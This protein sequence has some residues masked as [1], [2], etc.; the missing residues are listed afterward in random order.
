MI[1]SAKIKAIRDARKDDRGAANN[2]RKYL[3]AMFGWAVEDGCMP[4]NPAR[5]VRKLKYATDGFHNWATE[6]VLQFERRHPIG[7]KARL[8]FA[9]LL[10]LGVRR[11]DVVELGPEMVRDG[12]I[13]FV[14]RKT[15]YKRQDPTHKP[16]LPELADIIQAS[17]IGS[18]TYLETAYGKPFTGAGFGGWFRDRCDEAGLPNCTA[19][20]LRKAGATIA[21]ERGATVHQLMAIFDW[22]TPSQA[23]VYTR[24]ADRKRLAQAAMP[25]LGNRAGEETGAAT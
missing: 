21:A 10:F 16:I 8:A 12:V 23:E 11:G 24:A 25:L 2:R 18:K 15:R 3:S 13:S 4:H 22:S 6:E 9:L 1:T 7:S 19:H 14:P 5:D 17:K 20:G